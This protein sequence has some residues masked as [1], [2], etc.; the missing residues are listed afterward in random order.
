MPRAKLIGRGLR[1]LSDEDAA[2]AEELLIPRLTEPPRKTYTQVERLATA[3]AAEVDPELAER[4][5]KAAR[6]A[7]VTGDDVP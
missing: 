7:P 4:R 1:E 5:R 6:E 3:I 2:K